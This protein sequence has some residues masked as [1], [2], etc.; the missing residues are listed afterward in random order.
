MSQRW[1]H[2]GLLTRKFFL[3]KPVRP[4]TTIIMATTSSLYISVLGII[5]NKKDLVYT[6]QGILLLVFLDLKPHCLFPFVYFDFSL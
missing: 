4:C 2:G 1:V 6:G 5:E 3:E